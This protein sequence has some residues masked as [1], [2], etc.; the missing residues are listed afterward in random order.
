MV[1]THVI[2]ELGQNHVT[3]IKMHHTKLNCWHKQEQMMTLELHKVESG[4]LNS[5][6][7]KGYAKYF[8]KCVFA[9][10]LN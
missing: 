3:V 1:L 8:L 7:R 2:P 10:I 5:K 9:N 4:I 6:I